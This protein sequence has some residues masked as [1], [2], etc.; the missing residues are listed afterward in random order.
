MARHGRQ[1]PVWQGKGGHGE[2]WQAIQGK[3][4]QVDKPDIKAAMAEVGLDTP[5]EV[6]EELALWAQALQKLVDGYNSHKPV[7]FDA[8]EVR[9]LTE[10]MQQM[11]EELGIQ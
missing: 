8:A 4:A 6:L 1:G 3:E 2:T 10:T 11:L 7:L 9:V 5:T